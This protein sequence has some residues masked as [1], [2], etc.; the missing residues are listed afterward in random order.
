MKL[1]QV[2]PALREGKIITRVRQKESGSLVFFVKIEDA[3]LK[4]KFISSSG[5]TM[6]WA[7]YTLKTED[8]ISDNWEIAG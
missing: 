6:K 3:K 4:F 5:E 7:S 8:V 1:E 2:L